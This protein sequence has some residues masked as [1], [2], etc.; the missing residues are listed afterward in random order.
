[1]KI[2]VAAPSD[3]PR[4]VEIYNQAIPSHTSTADTVPLRVE[5]RAAWFAE[6]TPDK[7]PIFVAELGSR[8]AGWCSLSAYRPG[9]LALRFTAEISCYIDHASRR[10]GVGTALVNY[11]LAACP[12][13]QIKNVFAIL[14]ENNPASAPMLRKLG[15]EQWGFLPRVADFEGVECGQFYFGKRVG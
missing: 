2:R 14:L 10:S 8:V 11:A 5:D 9:R 6:H 7:Y 4:V 13:L 15:F 3:L 12:K 1:M